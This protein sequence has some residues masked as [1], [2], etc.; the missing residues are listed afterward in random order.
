[1][2]TSSLQYIDLKENALEGSLSKEMMGAIPVCELTHVGS[3]AFLDLAKNKI[4]GE[5]PDCLFDASSKLKEISLGK[6]ITLE[7]AIVCSI[8][9]GQ[10]T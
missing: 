1:M 6:K 5:L 3:L 2:K 9:F 4:K 7:Q 10:M 8:L